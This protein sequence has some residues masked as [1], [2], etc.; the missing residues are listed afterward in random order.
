[1]HVD[2]SAVVGLQRGP[3]VELR[4]TF[5]VDERPVAAAGKDLAVQPGARELAAAD[6]EDLSLADVL[7]RRER[8]SY[9]EQVLRLQTWLV[10]RSA[11]RGRAGSESECR[12]RHQAPAGHRR[13][14]NAHALASWRLSSGRPLLT[15]RLR[16][17][18]MGLESL[19]SLAGA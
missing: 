19:T 13:W 6:D 16:P 3:D 11:A 18:G 5:R 9:R 17:F 10:L 2:E 12:N 14:V 1:M 7:R 8:G 4:H 15:S